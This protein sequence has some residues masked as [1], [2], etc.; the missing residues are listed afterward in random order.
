MI[1]VIWPTCNPAKSAR[2]TVAWKDR[3]YDVFA[4]TDESFGRY[5]GYWSACNDIISALWGNMD[6]PVVIVAADDLFPDPRPAEEVLEIYRTRFPDHDGVMQPCGDDLPGTKE[7]CG[8]PW[9]GRK[10]IENTYNG[11]G[12]YY[13]GYQQFFGDQEL[14]NVAQRMGKL[15]MHTGLTQRHEHWLRPGIAKLD[16]QTANDRFWDQDKATY[17]WRKSQGF[18]G[19]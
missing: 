15:W 17:Y 9:I 1:P 2:A 19:A 4:W 6:W 13:S 7:I 11:R 5:L 18:P 8:S 14:M 12:P 3:G 16:Y 10:F